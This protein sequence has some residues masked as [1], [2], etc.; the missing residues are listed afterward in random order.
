MKTMMRLYQEGRTDY[1]STFFD[2]INGDT[3]TKQTKGLAYLF[4]RYPKL[5]RLLLRELN[6][7]NPGDTPAFKED[8]DFVQVDAE[9]LAAGVHKIRRDITLSLFQGN[10]KK[11]VIVIEAK[12]AGLY[13]KAQEVCSQL[14]AYLDPNNFP[15]D[16]G[17]P[18]YGVTLTKYKLIYDT[19]YQFLSLQWTDIVELINEMIRSE[20]KSGEDTIIAKQY[21]DFIHG[22]AKGMKYYEVEVLSVSAGKTHELTYK[23][24]IHACPNSAKGYIYKTPLFITFRSGGGGEM[25]CLYKID[26]IVVLDPFT[27]SLDAVLEGIQHELAA[28]IKTYITER[29]QGGYGFNHPG[30][31]YRFY[32]L[33]RTDLI[34]LQ[35]RP[36]PEKNAMGARYYT[37]AELLKGE[38][39]VKNV[40]SSR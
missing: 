26:D 24:C 35:H 15:H 18:V 17:V 39:I 40:T 16:A 13:A 27:P 34:L 3:E 25:H 9:M 14:A 1:H 37:L 6:R 33:S 28:R 29:I 5:I 38:K 31:M 7:R 30:E 2:L 22:V 20:K 10:R 23:H 36:K 12:S 8:Y 21:I 32:D 4:S 11:L 19:G